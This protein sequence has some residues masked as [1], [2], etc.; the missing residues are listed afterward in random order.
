MKTLIKRSTLTAMIGATICASLTGCTLHETEWTE[1]RPLPET[2]VPV[3]P[4]PWEPGGED[5]ETVL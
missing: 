5:V 2:E 4:A 1:T 3:T